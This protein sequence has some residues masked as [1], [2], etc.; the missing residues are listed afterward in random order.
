MLILDQTKITITKNKLKLP[1]GCKLDILIYVYI[2]T[3][4]NTYIH[5]YMHTYIYT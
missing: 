5:T 3:N 4:I 1:K 2:H